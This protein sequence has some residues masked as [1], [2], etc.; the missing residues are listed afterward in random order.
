MLN[1][2]DEIQKITPQVDHRVSGDQLTIFYDCQYMRLQIYIVDRENEVLW[3][4]K[5]LFEDNY[6]IVV[7]V[8]LSVCHY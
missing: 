2:V 5:H 3:F 4:L 8:L 7:N 1:A 6:A